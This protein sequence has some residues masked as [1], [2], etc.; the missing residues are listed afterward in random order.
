MTNDTALTSLTKLDYKQRYKLRDPKKTWTA[1]A[2]RDAKNR[3]KKKGLPF[4]ISLEYLRTIVPDVCPI[5]GTAFKWMGN[6]KIV[7]ESPSLDRIVPSLGY[8]EGNVAIISSRANNIKSYATWQEILMVS[9]W[10]KAQVEQ[11]KG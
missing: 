10:V 5:F 7:P 6:G 9:N 3:A 8:I 11:N 1:Y 4:N 2:I